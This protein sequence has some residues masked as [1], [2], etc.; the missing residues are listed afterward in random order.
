[1]AS[2]PLEGRVAI[3]TG[4]GRGL[5]RAHALALASAGVAVV[6]NNRS[7]NAAAKVVDEITTHGG[8]AVAHVGD[9]ADW[10]T[11]EGLIDQAVAEFG[12]LHI[13]VNNAG[14]T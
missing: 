12:D 3:V 13:L 9:V 6:V 11:A 10:A 2:L 5:G 1:M 8:R 7:A 14:I 4:A